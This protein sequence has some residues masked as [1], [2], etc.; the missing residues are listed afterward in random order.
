MNIVFMSMDT[1]PSTLWARDLYDQMHIRSDFRKWFPRMCQYGF[2][3]GRD[4]EYMPRVRLQDEGGRTVQRY[5]KDY[6]I[7]QDMA[8][9]LCKLHHTAVSAAYRP[10]PFDWDV[11]L[12]LLHKKPPRRSSYEVQLSD[13]DSLVTTTQIA[14]EYGCGAK[15]LPT[16]IVATLTSKT[17][18]K[19]T[20]PTHCLVE[21]EGLEPSIVQAE[22]IFTIDKS[23]VKRFVGHLTPEEM[24][25]V[26]DAVKI[27]LALNPMGSI[28][29]LKPIVR[30]TAAYA[31]P[32]VVDGKPPVYPYTPIKSDFEDAGTVEEMML[33]TELQSAV[34]AMIQRL[35]YSFT[36]NPSL[37]TSP[38]RKKQVTEILTEAEKYIWRIKEEIRC[39]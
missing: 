26:D 7:T 2:I 11:L 30:S 34:H 39:A 35:E 14:K 28:Q 16:L 20:Q 23:R 15:V 22:Q 37:L 31:P 9:K 17:E 1:L 8:K 21:P 25:R 38:K 32:E 13:S 3:E 6:R 24:G 33:Y 18:K 27:S 10:Q 29:K 36:F 19:A 5:V 4:Y 12:G